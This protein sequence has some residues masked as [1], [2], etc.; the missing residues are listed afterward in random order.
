MARNAIKYA[1]IGGSVIAVGGILV[2]WFI[3]H[4]LAVSLFTGIVTGAVVFFS[5][6]RLRHPESNYI[7]PRHQPGWGWPP[8]WARRK[9]GD[10]RDARD[11]DSPSESD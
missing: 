11:D 1:A 4:N 8:L 3:G 9:W 6:A 5:V 2:F 7:T 10:L